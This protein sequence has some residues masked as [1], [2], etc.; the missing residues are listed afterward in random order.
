MSVCR[1][2]IPATKMQYAPT[3]MEALYANAGQDLK[4]METQSV[5]VSLYMTVEETLM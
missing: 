2:E 4:G 3:S 1:V 5:R